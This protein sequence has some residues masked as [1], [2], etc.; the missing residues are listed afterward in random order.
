MKYLQAWFNFLEEHWTGIIFTQTCAL[1]ASALAGF[2]IQGVEQ[3]KWDLAAMWTG[4]GA[5]ATAAAAAWGKWFVISKYNTE[6]GQP[7]S[8]TGAQTKGG[9][10]P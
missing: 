1:V 7:A 2:W 5:I 9:N 6:G 4:V 10:T 8:M 3:G